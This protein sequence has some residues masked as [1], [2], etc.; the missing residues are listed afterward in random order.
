MT[1]LEKEACGGQASGAAAGMLAPFS[2]NGDG[3]DPFFRLCLESLRQYPNW[4]S[5]VKRVSGMSF[6]YS[7]TGS[8]YAAFHDADVLALESRREWQK[9]FGIEPELVEGE[10]LARMEPQLSSSVRCALFHPEETH[11]YAP[12]YVKVL[13]QACR[14][15]GAVIRDRLGDFELQQAG[16]CAY[17]VT[18]PAERLQLEADKLIVC[19]GAW[20][21]AWERML[22]IRIPVYPIRGQICAYEM[23]A[24]A[25]VHSGL[26]VNHVV[27]CSQGY[28][29]PKANGT[30]VC[31]ASEDVA[32]F[33]N[34][35]TD[36]GIRRI[37][38]W[39]RKLFPLLDSIEP[40]HRWA[41]LRPATQD[42]YPL[43]GYAPGNRSVIL[44]TGHYRNGILLSPVTGRIAAD[45]AEERD[46]AIDISRFRPE[47]FGMLVQ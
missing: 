17:V 47:R 14:Q 13:E 25:P 26:S 36:T 32:G 6:E 37:R 46:P 1:L 27:F 42:G 11:L 45:L 20:S 18:G 43:I 2:E 10:R 39:N 9:P 16:E 22:G 24:G 34:S 12:D 5:E 38:N 21:S 8:L 23:G 7:Q 4:Q 31:G 44:A 35:V 40:F 33:D 41:G 15:M 3:A 29:V 19:T 28:A 30:L